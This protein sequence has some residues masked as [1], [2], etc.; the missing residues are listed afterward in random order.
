[1]PQFLLRAQSEHVGG[2]TPQVAQLDVP[3]LR[4]QNC[5]C[6]VG[7][8]L[9]GTPKGGGIRARPCRGLSWSNGGRGARIS[10]LHSAGGWNRHWSKNAI[11]KS[12]GK[13]LPVFRLG[14]WDERWGIS[15]ETSTRA[16]ETEP[17]P[18]AG[19]AGP[20]A[21]RGARLRGSQASGPAAKTDG[22][23]HDLSVS[24]TKWARLA[25]LCFCESTSSD[26]GDPRS[27]RHW[28]RA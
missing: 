16:R 2:G 1:M 12:V 14:C 20:T 9:H 22:R 7:S 11:T 3:R 5:G 28:L 4:P 10:S 17:P 19:R 21:N 26:R 23:P 13:V 15:S 8:R 6:R 25:T 18:H 27:R 24:C